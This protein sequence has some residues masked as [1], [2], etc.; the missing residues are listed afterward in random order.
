MSEVPHL[1]VDW[2]GRWGGF[3]TS[4]R[5]VLS[6]SPGGERGSFVASGIPLRTPFTSLFVHCAVVF[7]WLFLSPWFFLLLPESIPISPPPGMAGE[8]IYFF[9]AALPEI[10][11]VGGAR[12][13][14]AGRSGGR[15]AHH[16]LQTII[17]ARGLKVVDTIVDA[18]KLK[19]P[20]THDRVANLLS[21]SG[22]APAPPL[23][24]V[25]RPLRQTVLPGSAPTPVAPAPDVAVP[26]P[27]RSLSAA[28][29]FLPSAP[30]PLEIRNSL[31]RPAE[32]V[33]AAPRLDAVTRVPQLALPAGQ[34]VPP[35]APLVAR[36]ISDVSGSW[37]TNAAAAVAPPKSAGGA[38]NGS[39][40]GEPGS[41]A[42]SESASGTGGHGF[43]SAGQGDGVGGGNAQGL[44]VSLNPGDKFGI[45]DGGADGSFAMSPTGSDT[46]GLGGSGGGAG[47]GHGSGPGSGA[48]GAGP[49][50][51]TTGTGPG[52]AN[53]AVGISPLPGPG[54][55]GQVNGTLALVPGVTIQGN[56]I[57]IPSFASAPGG[58]SG[59]GA[60][61]DPRRPPT[62]VVIASSR[63]GGGMNAYGALKGSR[64]YTTYIDTRIGT[65]VLQ[66]SDPASHPGFETD[67]TPPEPMRTELGPDIKHAHVLVK[68]VMGKTGKLQNLRVLESPDPVLSARLLR[69]LRQW[70][71]RPAFKL[72][73]A[74]DVDVILGFGITTR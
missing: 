49:G 74:I 53:V 68:C 37:A 1:L 70:L 56:V 16:P 4:L 22:A 54:G 59:P 38:G 29:Q 62:I 13:G 52:A 2:D 50:S 69:A 45:P 58:P 42:A 21:F 32:A 43:S 7:A 71:F 30:P 8:T 55:A 18:P 9:P 44:I 39:G 51:G 10:G 35:V 11:D 28:A 60:H 33:V 66:Y 63:S 26:A 36:N 61:T 46:G 17:I 47:I 67:L 15:H 27:L 5:V 48:A 34:M 73:A 25:S 12:S 72:D 20:L 41:L 57:T 40:G 65:A 23:D 14:T 24:A 6:R 3:V 19:L 64:V 31:S